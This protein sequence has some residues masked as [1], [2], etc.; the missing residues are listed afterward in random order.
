MKNLLLSTFLVSA[1][2]IGTA[3]PLFAEDAAMQTWTDPENRFSLVQP[4]GWRIDGSEPWASMSSPEGA[5]SLWFGLSEATDA[6]E[7][8]TAAWVAVGDTV[9][10][11]QTIAPAPPRD[12]FEAATAF[13]YP[14]DGEVIRQAVVE[15]R[16]GR[17]HITLIRGSMAALDRR[18]AQVNIAVTGFQPAGAA[19][20]DLTG[21]VP[22]EGCDIHVCPSPGSDPPDPKCPAGARG[23]GLLR[24]FQRDFRV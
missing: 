6:T 7:A 3:T 12:G 8:V 18:G 19:A 21:V 10:R 24:V 11:P 13:I 16:D 9:A 20:V 2:V 22:D 17:L 15:S 23:I 4:E 14:P 1:A 5:I